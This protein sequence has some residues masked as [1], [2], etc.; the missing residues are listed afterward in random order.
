MNDMYLSRKKVKLR[1]QATCL[2][3]G[4]VLFGIALLATLRIA[5]AQDNIAKNHKD[6]AIPD[7]LKRL[8]KAYPDTLL[9]AGVNS[10]RWADGTTMIY[11]DKKNK[12]FSK[13][14]DSPDLED[15][16]SI[17]YPEKW[18]PSLPVNFDPGRIRYEPFFFKMYGNS[19]EA[20]RAKLRPVVWLPGVAD[21]KIMMT[22]IN[23]VHEKLNRVSNEIVGL[24]REIVKKVT[25]IQG[26][27]VWRNIK[28]TKR[29][30]A[31][32]FGIAI[33]V[34][35]N[36]SDYWMWNKPNRNNIYIYKNRFPLEVAAIFEKHGFIWG[37]KWYHYDTMHF[38]YR[39]ELLQP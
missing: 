24:P 8:V 20:V 32:S 23:K 1:S 37:G 33:D 30:S 39:P 14:L 34:G 26:T 27:F 36:V 3:F 9:G 7:G 22:S 11:D 31:H 2:C 12:R 29:Q 4:F 6:N 38:E 35:K 16:M 17:A 28:G 15:Q 21:K 25:Q 18:S 5:L 10:L 13:K 19:P